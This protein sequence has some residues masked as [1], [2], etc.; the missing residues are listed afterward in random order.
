MRRFNPDDV[1]IRDVV[2]VDEG[3]KRRFTLKAGAFTGFREGG[4]SIGR[5][6]I[7][8]KAAL[9]MAD[10]LHPKYRAIGLVK[11]SRIRK[12][13]HLGADGY[14]GFPFNVEA[15]AYPDDQPFER[16]QVAHAVLTL[17]QGYT[18]PAAR[19]TAVGTLARTVFK[20]PQPYFLGAEHV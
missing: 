20:V 13:K 11:V 9:S 2:S 1:E 19:K 3:G 15:D 10:F 6:R 5:K 12:F 17:N 18:T 16:W 7:L 14:I 4:C 8:H